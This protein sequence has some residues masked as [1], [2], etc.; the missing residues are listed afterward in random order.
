MGPVPTVWEPLSY[1]MNSAPLSG[2]SSAS[3]SMS[4]CVCASLAAPGSMSDGSA[5]LAAP[6]SMSSGMSSNLEGGSTHTN[7]QT[8]I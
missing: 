7:T 3:M 5:S 1:C 6:V 4:M 2:S 8:V